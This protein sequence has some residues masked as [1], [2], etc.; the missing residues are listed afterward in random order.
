MNARLH[1]GFQIQES[2]A[3]SSSAKNASPTLQIPD[4]LQSAQ[5]R[6]TRNM[7][8]GFAHSSPEKTRSFVLSD[9]H[10]E[11]RDELQ[12]A[13]TS[14]VGTAPAGIDSCAPSLRAT[15]RKPCA[16]GYRDRETARPGHCRLTSRCSGRPGI[17]C[18]AAGG[19]APRAHER[20]RARVLRV[21]RAAAELNR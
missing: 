13:S 2:W 17:K 1:S 4:P 11:S 19:R 18:S 9:L 20:Y 5:R 21:R 7:S 8:R 6:H 14:L 15:V 3:R 16:R 10:A 12:E